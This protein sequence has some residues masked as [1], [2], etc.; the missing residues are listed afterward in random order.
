MEEKGTFSIFTSN[1]FILEM[2]TQIELR[3]M[4]FYAYHGVSPQETA[5][6][7]TFIVDLRLT[8]PLQAAVASDRLEDTMNYAVIYQLVKG[9]ME[10]PSRLIEHVAGR[11]LAS[12]HRNF[13]QISHIYLRLAKLNPPFGGDLHSA[14]VIL[15]ETY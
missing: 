4:K 5:V 12:L 7:N 10:Q 15:E 9:E 3:E 11:I 13:P 2:T 1:L 8:A 14:A 6:G